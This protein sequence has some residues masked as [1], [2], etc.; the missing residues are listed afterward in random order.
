M[1]ILALLIFL[2]AC[3]DEKQGRI[4]ELQ[5]EVI[6]QR[7]EIIRLNQNLDDCDELRHYW[8]NAYLTLLSEVE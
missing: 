7:Q 4:Y 2:T 5:N 1:R 3:A 8:S 6:E